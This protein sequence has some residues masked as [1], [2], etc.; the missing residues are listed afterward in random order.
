MQKI[1]HTVIYY[2]I[3]YVVTFFNYYII[4]KFYFFTQTVV[5]FSVRLEKP[6]DILKNSFSFSTQ[7]Q[8]LLL[9]IDGT[10]E[11]FERL[12][13]HPKMSHHRMH[14]KTHRRKTNAFIASLKI[15]KVHN[16]VEYLLWF[17]NY[18]QTRHVTLC[19]PAKA[20]SRIT[21]Q[22]IEK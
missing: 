16:S 7:E 13:L 17:H 19:I 20:N 21:F 9:L 6:Q 22:I 15:Y 1:L 11:Y 4:S 14:K 5:S 12:L 8:K 3:R 2:T 10:N 18:V